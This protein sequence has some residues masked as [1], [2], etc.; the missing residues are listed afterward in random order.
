[1][2]PFTDQVRMLLR[3][4]EVLHVDETTARADGD[5]TYVHVACT[6]FL[7]HL[8]FCGEKRGIILAF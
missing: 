1:L 4:A 8:Q 3:Q 7:T 5:L 6:E 2:G